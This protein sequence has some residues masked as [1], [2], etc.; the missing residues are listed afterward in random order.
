LVYRNFPHNLWEAVSGLPLPVWPRSLS[1]NVV[2]SVREALSK[3]QTLQVV[4][5]VR[6]A[7]G[8]PRAAEYA[9]CFPFG[10]LFALLLLLRLRS[11]PSLARL[12]QPSVAP[13]PSPEQLPGVMPVFADLP[14][15]RLDRLS[16][17]YRGRCP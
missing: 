2:I 4:T 10:L 7:E 16:P 11:L 15:D 13:V 8:L 14:A 3:A 5:Y 6:R 9:R 12:R 17:R 1:S